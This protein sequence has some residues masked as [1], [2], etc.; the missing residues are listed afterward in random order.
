MASESPSPRSQGRSTPRWLTA[1]VVVVAVALLCGLGYML[2]T[3]SLGSHDSGPASAGASAAP[4][5]PATIS[6]S[7]AW[8]KVLGGSTQLTDVVTAPDG[9]IVVIG[10][11]SASDGT[12]A[13]DSAF[14][15]QDGVRQ[16]VVAQFTASGQ[17][18][19]SK[20]LA[21]SGTMQLTDVA[22]ASD[23]TVA[24]TGYAGAGTTDVPNVGNA[25]LDSAFLATLTPQ[26]AI[27]WATTLAT[28]PHTPDLGASGNP[29]FE[30]AIT[31]QGTIVTLGTDDLSQGGLA[32]SG[33]D[34]SGNRLWHGT[35]TTDEA[36]SIISA[37]PGTSG[38]AL[39][40]ISTT[41]GNGSSAPALVTIDPDGTVASITTLSGDSAIISATIASDGSL[42]TTAASSGGA[43][44]TKRSPL[45]T[46]T[47][48]TP[49]MLPASC[50]LQDI[51]VAADGGIVAV[52]S[53]ISASNG[54]ATD[55]FIAHLT[56]GGAVDWQRHLGGTGAD[57]FTGVAVTGD[58]S[59]VVVGATASTDGDFPP[60]KGDRDA[61]VARINP[62]G[63]LAWAKT[64]GGTD[65]DWFSSVAVAADG[66]ITAA[67]STD[68]TDGD[69]PPTKGGGDALIVHL[70]ANGNLYDR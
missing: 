33:F 22:V 58:G 39:A 52:G 43:V 32:A 2:S 25:T 31:T 12:L 6:A 36:A 16:A 17:L 38:S 11:I 46:V 61:V 1:L 70:D 66:T 40:V 15:M 44:V 7:T 9:S 5:R 27:A 69:F 48:Q 10:A 41:S 37:A 29:Y 64:Y 20:A 55:G 65:T 49:I 4:S 54:A 21:G 47:W 62:D 51:A 23:G 8:S 3:L 53:T 59:I 18:A 68:S 57:T 63:T 42:I 19:W 35:V 13:A 60:A 14:P 50:G 24:V 56:S 30:L 34:A 26:G 67:G 28:R 45:G